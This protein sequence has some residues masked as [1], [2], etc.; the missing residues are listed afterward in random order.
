MKDK[1]L[2]LAALCIVVNIALWRLSSGGIIF[3]GI[4]SDG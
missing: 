1:T 2:A 3:D 4:I